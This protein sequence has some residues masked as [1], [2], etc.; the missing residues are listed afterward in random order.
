MGD[1]LQSQF[2]FLLFTTGVALLLFGSFIN[3]RTR[4]A[5]RSWWSGI[6]FR[7]VGIGRDPELLPRRE[8]E[9]A[10]PDRRAARPAAAHSEKKDGHGHRTSP[11]VEKLI[12]RK[13]GR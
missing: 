9:P 13:P 11:H 7:P 2:P 5:L 10:V 3:R 8:A 12:A 6:D 4:F 1:Q